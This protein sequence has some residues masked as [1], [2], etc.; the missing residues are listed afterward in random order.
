MNVPLA[1]AASKS[2]SRYSAPKPS[3]ACQTISI[4]RRYRVP[5][6]PVAT[7]AAITA[8][9]LAVE[10]VLERTVIAAPHYRGPASDHFDGRRFHNR[11]HAERASF[12]KWQAT[13]NAG[14]WPR[15]IDA[16][17]GLPPPARVGG[18]RM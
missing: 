12:L 8:G 3:H 6:G 10:A 11:E 2:T 14:P 9:I 17:S 1:S 4:R 7:T 5:M 16:P 13:R 15:W 18:G